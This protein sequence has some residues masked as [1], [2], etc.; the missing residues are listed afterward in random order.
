MSKYFIQK[1][2]HCAT[3]KYLQNVEVTQYSSISAGTTV[4]ADILLLY[5]IFA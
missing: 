2:Q 3:L 4:P 1:V 5:I